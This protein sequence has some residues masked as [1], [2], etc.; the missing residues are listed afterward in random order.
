LSIETGSLPVSPQEVRLGS[1]Q[2]S[3]GTLLCA[4]ITLSFPAG[5]EFLHGDSNGLE[6]PNVDPKTKKIRIAFPMIERLEVEP[7]TLVDAQGNTLSGQLTASLGSDGSAEDPETRGVHFNRLAFG[8]AMAPA[9]FIESGARANAYSSLSFRVETSGA[10]SLNASDHTQVAFDGD[11]SALTLQELGSDDL[12]TLRLSARLNQR[13]AAVHDDWS[14]SAGIGPH[15]QTMLVASER[16]GFRNFA[17]PIVSLDFQ[18]A[19]RTGAR[20]IISTR[21]ALDGGFIDIPRLQ[22]L[23]YSTGFTYRTGTLPAG[24]QTLWPSE[25]TYEFSHLKS[26]IRGIGMEGETHALGGRWSFF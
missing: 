26:S 8:M 12:R 14:L 24:R 18:S 3:A 16:F 9:Y 23:Q 13:L 6:I 20:F 15:F 5:F 17:G 1:L 19:F 10:I 11:L 25:I 4:D 21:V 2:T 22:T 7:V